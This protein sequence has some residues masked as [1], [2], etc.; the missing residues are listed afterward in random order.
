MTRTFD[1]FDE[2]AAM[3]LTVPPGSEVLPAPHHHLPTP[4]RPPPHTPALKL[5]AEPAPARK[6][7]R[8]PSIAAEL[9]IV[10]HLPVRAGLWLTPY[11]DGL[12]RELGSIALLRLDGDE[13]A[14]QLLRASTDAPSLTLD[15][16]LEEA[17]SD[18]A[19]TT[20][21]WVVRP[22][23]ASQPSDLVRCGAGRITILSSADEAAIVAA[24]QSIKDLAQAA[25]QSQVSLPSIGMAIVGVDHANAAAVIERLNRTTISFLGV[26]VKLVLAMP[27]MDAGVKST[28]YVSFAGHAPPALGEV[29]NW[30][31]QARSKSATVQERPAVAGQLYKER[32]ELEL[33]DA[34]RILRSPAPAAPRPAPA[35][36]EVPAAPLTAPIPSFQARTPQ[37]PAPEFIPRPTAAPPDAASPSPVPPIKLQ[38]KPSVLMEPKQPSRAVEP[39]D[40][41]KPIPLAK[42]V[43]GLTPLPIRSP[44]HERV[45][46]AIDAAGQ[47][48]LLAREHA[49]RELRIVESWAFAHREI[50]AMACPQHAFNRV[51]KT[52]CHI[53]SAEPASLAD[54]HGTDYC[55]HVL[56][57]VEVNGQTGWYAAPLNAASR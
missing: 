13:P 37:A 48:H 27:R 41:G 31:D 20:D 53:F 17:I 32:S 29:M 15:G 40:R 26:E 25:E 24:Y 38:P 56:A 11:A 12:A 28:R 47:M 16:V 49:M 46:I 55:L 14:L 18:L 9:L 54:L 30:I 1:P 8:A 19:A 43:K 2:L 51:G 36:P 50:I 45:E 52:I 21:M 34:E 7:I 39:D 23:T 3:F 42:Y 5:A 44:G 57:P 4:T 35:M 22:S 6:A 33:L 10:G